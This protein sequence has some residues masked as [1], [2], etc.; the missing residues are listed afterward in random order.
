M[1]KST[2]WGA[3]GGSLVGL[4]VLLLVVAPI[5]AH[6]VH[7]RVAL[8]YKTKRAGEWHEELRKARRYGWP[9]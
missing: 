5:V 6:F 9:K 1:A 8:Y 2:L 4:A 3:V 7:K